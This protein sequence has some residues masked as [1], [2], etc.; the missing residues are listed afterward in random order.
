MVEISLTLPLS[1]M[2][3]ILL[4][5]CLI[6]GLGIFW[7]FYNGKNELQKKQSNYFGETYFSCPDSAVSVAAP[8][9][10]R[11][12][13]IPLLTNSSRSQ[14]TVTILLWTKFFST[15]FTDDYYF[16][17]PG[18]ETFSRYNC[19]YQC[20]VT[21]DRKLLTSVDAVLFHITNFKSNVKLP[22]KRRLHQR[23]ILYGIEA[24]R[25]IKLPWQKIDGL[26]NWTMTYREDS[27]LPVRYGHFR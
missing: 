12:V 27:D 3:N 11:L 8:R 7:C 18:N 1:N 19:Q 13:N 22:N 23:W 17:L 24:P 10:P 14:N 16:F 5:L 21:A 20:S 4:V 26:F 25:L 15:Q 9:Q 6:T 2:K